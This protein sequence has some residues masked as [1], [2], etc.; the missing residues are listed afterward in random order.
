MPQLPSKWNFFSLNF[1]ILSLKVISEYFQSDRIFILVLITILY[2]YT[3]FILIF[4]NTKNFSSEVIEFN[5]NL[6]FLYVFFQLSVR[7][8]SKSTEPIV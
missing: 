8:K 1:F 5:N 4:T 2:Y 6:T 3:I 7:E